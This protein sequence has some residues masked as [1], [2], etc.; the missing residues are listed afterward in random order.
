MRG[1]IG[2]ATGKTAATDPRIARG[3]EKRLGVKRGMYRRHRE[4]LG[5]D[6]PL[7]CGRDLLSPSQ[8]VAYGYMLG[9]YL[10]DGYLAGLPD[11]CRFEISL[12]ASIPAW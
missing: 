6:A 11:S 3:V 2:W 4:A 9:M 7:P 8:R 12:D 1:R 5:V 10:G